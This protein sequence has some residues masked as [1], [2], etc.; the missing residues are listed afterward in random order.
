MEL[1]TELFY[2]I[3]P[4]LFLRFL[5]IGYPYISLHF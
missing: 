3:I 1:C 5:L 4:T 2:A